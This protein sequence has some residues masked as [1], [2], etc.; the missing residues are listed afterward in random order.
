MTVPFCPYRRHNECL[1]FNES[2]ERIFVAWNNLHELHH[3]RRVSVYASVSYL[4]ENVL[5]RNYAACKQ[6]IEEYGAKSCNCN[7]VRKKC[8]GYIVSRLRKIADRS[9][10]V[11]A[12]DETYLRHSVEYW[13]DLIDKQPDYMSALITDLFL[14]KVVGLDV[15]TRKHIYDMVGWYFTFPEHTTASKSADIDHVPNNSTWAVT[16]AQEARE[17]GWD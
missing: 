9:G 13:R 14:A 4:M 11:R 1:M 12:E 10:R 2:A 8:G 6:C 7:P 16:T 3:H 15:Y 17:S 5:W